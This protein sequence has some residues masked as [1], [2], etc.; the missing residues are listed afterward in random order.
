MWEVGKQLPRVHE[1]I[2]PA[3]VIEMHRK[4]DGRRKAAPA[5]A[6][7]GARLQ[8]RPG[9][10]EHP[11]LRTTGAQKKYR[12]NAGAGSVNFAL[13]ARRCFASRTNRAYDEIFYARAEHLSTRCVC[14]KTRPRWFWKLDARNWTLG[15]KAKREFRKPAKATFR[16]QCSSTGWANPRVETQK[17]A[18]TPL[19]GAHRTP[20]ETPFAA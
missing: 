14:A 7:V 4:C 17:M 10:S 6:F 3:R 20:R 8:P 18:P 9:G 19:S 16:G 2:Y 5:F 1:R 15:K 13:A 11:P 12:L